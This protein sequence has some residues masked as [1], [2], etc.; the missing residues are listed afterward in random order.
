M[1]LWQRRPRHQTSEC[2][3]QLR[4]P[5]SALLRNGSSGRKETPPTTLRT[6]TGEKGQAMPSEAL[7]SRTSFDVVNSFLESAPVD[8][9]GM[10]QALG[11]VVDMN[12]NFED[13]DVSGRICRVDSDPSKYRIDVNQRHS[14]RRKRFT[15]AHEISHYLLHRDQIGD[16][17]TDTA[18]YRS[19]LNN[20]MESEANR[21]AAQLIMPSNLL[22]PV[23]RA[24]FRTIADL[25]NRFEVSEDA[26]RIRLK[27]LRLD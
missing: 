13:D 23:W 20:Y 8:L 3:P 12:A 16:G 17:V 24:G 14:K 6:L 7:G 9:E 15:L 10:A 5:Q 21:L 4:R 18:M 27:Q 26:L 1:K 22:R 25:C 19:R 11:I 2:T